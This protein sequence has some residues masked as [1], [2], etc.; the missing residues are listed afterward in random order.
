MSDRTRTASIQNDAAARQAVA[1]QGRALLQV[2][3]SPSFPVGAYA[4]S[5]GLEKAVE[6]GWLTNRETLEA[7]LHDV[8]AHGSLRNDLILLVE[9]HR[10]AA[11]ADREGLRRLADLSSALQPSAERYLEA[12]QQGRSFLLQ[13]DASWSMHD[14][15]GRTPS[16]QEPADAVLMASTSPRS[17]PRRRGPKQSAAKTAAIDGHDAQHERPIEIVDACLGPP[18]RGDDDKANEASTPLVGIDQPQPLAALFAETQPSVPVVLGVAAEAHAIGPEDTALAYAIAFGSNLISAA[19]RLS[20][21]GQTD[22]QRTIAAL[23]PTLAAIA[24]AAT[25]CN[26]D[27]LGSAT[28]RADIASQQHETQYTRLFRS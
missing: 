24:T 20:V 17:S 8:V 26:V 6:I 22:G 18:L 21:I 12:T 10:L 16:D 5:H 28:F 11:R 3:L 1:R 7:W 25:T 27:E 23:M 4:Y 2:W 14:P 9:A 13:I 15:A 19:V